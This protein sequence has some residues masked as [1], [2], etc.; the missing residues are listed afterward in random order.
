MRCPSGSMENGMNG[1]EGIFSVEYCRG[2]RGCPRAALDGGDLARLIQEIVA[3]PGVRGVPDT[4]PEA[5]LYHR[6]FRVSLSLCPNAC[7]RPQIADFGVI[8]AALPRATGNTCTGCNVC[9]GVCREGA[10]S[11]RFGV[12]VIDYSRCVSCGE[13]ARACPCG[14]IEIHSTGFRVLV[15]GRLGRHPRLA[16][17]LGGLYTA[18]EATRLL[19]RSARLFLEHCG[20]G[21]RFAELLDRYDLA[22]EGLRSA[23]ARRPAGVSGGVR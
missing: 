3:P 16:R 19:E 9:T 13:C 15:G 21:R 2:F 7:S 11:P 14:S 10:I 12:P 22:G 1:D 5:G 8:G 18:A 20:E 23:D 4:D 6:K 17:E